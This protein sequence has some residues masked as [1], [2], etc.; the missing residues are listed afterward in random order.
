MTNKDFFTIFTNQS[1][2][3]MDLAK[4][5][6]VNN[7]DLNHFVAVVTRKQISGRGRGGSTW[8][9]SKV[10]EI[11]SN[12]ESSNFIYYNSMK[13]IILEELNF[14]PITF[15][16]PFK[17][18]KIPYE[19]ISSIISCA[20]YDSLKITENFIK[21]TAHNL[22]FNLNRSMYIK[23]PNDLIVCSNKNQ[24]NAEIFDFKKISGVLCETSSINGKIDNILVGIGLNFFNHPLL[25]KSNSFWDSLFINEVNKVQKR[26]I[27]KALSLE[28]FRRA[29]LN[30]FCESFMKEFIDYLCTPRDS[31]QLRSLV[32]ER[33]IPVGTFISVNKRQQQGSFLGLTENAE[34]V[35]SG[36]KDPII[37]ANID[38]IENNETTYSNK[39]ENNITKVSQNDPTLAIDFGN[40]TIHFSYLSS[41]SKKYYINISYDIILSGL[42][43]K[44]RDIF[45]PVLEGFTFDRKK[46]IE[47]LY[48]SVNSFEKTNS[49]L[50]K[51]KD[52]LI[53]LFPEIS[54][55]ENKITEQDIFNCVKITGNFESNRLG[56][57][58][59][60]KFLF[61][62]KQ[63]NNFKKNIITFSFGTA[64]TCEGVS[65][66]N[67]ILEN[68]IFPGIQMAF[69]ALNNYTALVPL[70]KA[71]SEMF[72]PKNKF[73]NQEI[74]VQRGVFLS[75][76]ASVIT[77]INTHSP[78]KCY[79]TGGNA[80]EIFKIICEIAPNNN[81][82]ITLVPSIE[83]DM[84]LEYKEFFLKN[85]ILNKNLLNTNDISEDTLAGVKK[86][87]IESLENNTVTNVMKTM[88]KARSP[89]KIER[90]LKPNL[91]DFRK[92]GNRLE[93]IDADMRID[94]YMTNKFQFHN[95]E[96]WRE[97]IL[98]GEVLV[99]RGANCKVRDEIKLNKIKP[100][101]KLKNFDQIWLFHPAEY[102]PDIIE[103]IDVILDDGDV[104]VFAKPP[105]L[106]IHA[107]GIYG[108][109]TFVNISAKMGYSDCAAVHRID[110]ETS[111]ILV[112]A[113][114]P[115]T[116]SIISEAFRHGN[117]DKLYIA[118]TKGNKK[119]PEKFRVILPIGEP[120]NSLIRL[121]LWINGKFPQY[122]ETWFAELASFDDFTMY[123][124]LPKT[125]RTNQIR[126]H[127]AAIGQWIVGDKMY[128]ED[129]NV[130]INFY[131]NGYTDWV[132][133]KT[134]FPRHML[135]NASI[136]ASKT[137]IPSLSNSPIICELYSD[138]MDSNIV[139]NLLNNSSIP[140]NINDQ[141]KYLKNLFLELLNL[142][143][144][145]FPEI[146]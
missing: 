21:S 99:E 97:R 59:A 144:N 54:F 32:L 31:M 3:T 26:D 7:S 140:F 70:F 145:K 18:I 78:C 90:N 103:D 51:I 53:N 37:S 80:E 40:T 74:Y 27:N 108:K 69:N 131:E 12:T 137:N 101:Y 67:E 143:F 114:K 50:I 116:R 77:T 82:D 55:I 125:G 19:W 34:L 133:E 83:T 109:N 43:N 126:I 87:I 22:P 96:S 4:S 2:S 20:I 8:Q 71:N 38:I 111:G 14:L 62:F 44:I 30:E 113:R 107:T 92:I 13:D 120:E 141:R 72:S 58:R 63:A 17:R 10:E 35:L 130:F 93:N 45:K 81:F 73:W 65:S 146:Q 121:K 100:T 56:A 23:W 84:I 79:F 64:V 118:I 24:K 52:F 48:T 36:I 49:S 98:K 142:N 29:I 136:M 41:N 88:I 104:C 15:I 33:S 5:S 25:E 68:F 112:S 85:K 6:E 117:I 105:N 115:E 95:R 139:R 123:A 135:H 129:E 28:G 11:S 138:L 89:M 134:L 94:S 106:V 66:T 57:D 76:A 86:K 47:L 132:H 75:T 60:L 9:Q 61:S 42:N 1:N 46:K 91:N 110:R 128:H 102:E 39:I 16:C 122:A 127:L 124:C 119:L